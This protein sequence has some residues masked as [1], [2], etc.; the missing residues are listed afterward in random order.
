MK[1]ILTLLGESNNKS[2][3]I[4]CRHPEASDAMWRDKQE[5]MER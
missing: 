4:V 3:G 2:Q 5:R 1:E